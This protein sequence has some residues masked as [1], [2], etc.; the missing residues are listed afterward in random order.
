MDMNDSNNPNVRSNIWKLYVIR[1][2][3]GCLVGL[4][5]IVL[6]F[7]NAGLTLR[8][9]YMLQ[10]G[11]AITILLLEIPSGYLSDRWGR[12]PTLIASFAA[13]TVGWILYTQAHDFYGF[14]AAEMC[15]GVGASLFSGTF[16]AM[17]YDSLLEHKEE[18]T[19]R[20]ITRNQLSFDLGAE[21]IC[22]LLGGLIALWSLAATQYVTAAAFAGAMFVACTLR[23]PHRHKQQEKR[24][25]KALWNVFSH[26]LLFHRGLRSITLIA[27]IINAMTLMIFWLTQPYQ[28]LIGLPLFLWGVTH[29]V[30]TLAGAV[31]A[32]Y[33]GWVEERADD[34]K[35][36]M[37]IAATIV[38]VYVGLALAPPHWAFLGFF[39]VSRI[40]WCLV[41][42][43]STDMVNR[44]ATSDVR[45]TVLSVFSF[46]GRVFFVL[47]SPWI[48]LLA[49][50]HG[51]PLALYVA[52][53]L[54]GGILLIVF[55]RLRTV[56]DELPR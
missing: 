48:G 5:V 6:L 55:I 54:G 10:S 28:K 33:A 46:G 21:S 35:I 7:Q 22:A 50:H 8:E 18:G 12:K 14:L 3:S 9:I 17:T 34:R 19:Y 51:L 40:A 16:E 24:H 56:W 13:G 52:G 39:L 41:G 42:P 4:P 29:A 53:I 44:M 30:I 32:Q 11:F 38:G 43:L 45:A 37:A 2:L 15:I 1:A 36:L 25:W 47:T 49:D 23:E 20:T 26:T 27:G 31:T